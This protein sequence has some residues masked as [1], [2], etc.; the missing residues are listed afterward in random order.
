MVRK[1]KSECSETR[2]VLSGHYQGCSVV[3][4][5]AEEL[6]SEE[7]SSVVVRLSFYASNQ[8]LAN[9]VACIALCR[10][11]QWSASWKYSK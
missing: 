6:S 4:Q 11:Q 2:I 3:H 5:A 9:E 10:P 1:V 7:V 8:A